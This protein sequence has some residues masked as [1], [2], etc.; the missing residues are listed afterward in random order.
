MGVSSSSSPA[1]FLLLPIPFPATIEAIRNRVCSIIRVNSASNSI[2][3]FSASS[4]EASLA[5]IISISARSI[6]AIVSEK[7]RK[8]AARSASLGGDTELTESELGGLLESSLSEGISPDTIPASQACFKRFSSALFC[9]VRSAASAITK[10]LHNNA[11]SLHY[12]SHPFVKMLP[13]H[14]TSWLIGPTNKTEPFDI[15]ND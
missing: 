9:L 11:L 13:R 1:R 4:L 6:L 7:T 8:F 3:L 14:L 2:L 5:L 10:A 12:Y 15:F